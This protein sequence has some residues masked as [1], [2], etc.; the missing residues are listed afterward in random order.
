M[1]DH[2]Q[3]LWHAMQSM[4]TKEFA[5][6]SALGEALH[7]F[8]YF[9]VGFLYIWVA[10]KIPDN[11]P[12]RNVFLH[13]GSFVVLCGATHAACLVVM[14]YANFYVWHVELLIKLISGGWSFVTM[15]VLYRYRFDVFQWIIRK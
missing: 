10:T 7:V 1:R 3:P 2:A 15:A 13:T 5:Y 11:L 12:L 8:S 14:F 9:I 4:F 6:L